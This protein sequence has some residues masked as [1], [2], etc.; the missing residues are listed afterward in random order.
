MWNNVEYLSVASSNLAKMR[1]HVNASGQLDN[2]LP[3]FCGVG[4]PWTR[5]IPEIS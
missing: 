2:F 1:Q 4:K 3:R 5:D